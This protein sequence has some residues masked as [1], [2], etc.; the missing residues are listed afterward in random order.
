MRNLL[1]AA[2][3]LLAF[4][5]GAAAQYSHGYA[6]GAPGGIST[7]GA[8]QATVHAGAGFDVLVWRKW[9]G[10]G[11]EAGYLTPTDSIDSGVFVTSPNG[12]LHIPVDW[13]RRLDPFVTAGYSL[14]FRSSTRNLWNF[15][16]GMNWWLADRWGLRFEVRDHV[17]SGSRS[18]V[19]YWNLR[20][21]VSFR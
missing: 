3:L 9:V 15:G 18:T 17:D 16:G 12:Y 5:F 11:A 10:F 21:G 4:S 20:F 19:H 14:F 8:N 2:F 6:F 1:L 7:R 13:D